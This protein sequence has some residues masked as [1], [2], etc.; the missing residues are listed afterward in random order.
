MILLN[1]R[2]VAISM[3][4][5]PAISVHSNNGLTLT[6]P[7]KSAGLNNVVDVVSCSSIAYMIVTISVSVPSVAVIVMLYSPGVALVIPAKFN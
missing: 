3:S 5:S 1:E 7:E 2:S 6:S 4:Y